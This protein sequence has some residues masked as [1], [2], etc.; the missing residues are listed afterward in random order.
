MAMKFE[1]EQYYELVTGSKHK[2]LIFIT[3]LHGNNISYRYICNEKYAPIDSLM[4]A[5]GP[6]VHDWIFKDE[7][8]SS[9]VQQNLRSEYFFDIGYEDIY[10]FS[11]RELYNKKN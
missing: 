1:K 8:R 2:A 7:E 4:E 5:D 11:A 3:K 9:F 6:H 10:K